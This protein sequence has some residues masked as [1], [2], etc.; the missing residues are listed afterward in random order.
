MTD[1]ERQRTMD[2]I[3]QQQAQFA[4]GMQRLE[5]QQ[6]RFAEQQTRFAEQQTKFSESQRR[7][8]DR[9]DQLRRVVLMTVRQFSRERRD[10]RERIAAL[11]DSQMRTEDAMR[12][13][14]ATTERNSMDIAALARTHKGDDKANGEG[15]G[16]GASS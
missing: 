5:V 1:E 7:A 9:I 14:T 12:S 16:G 11:V 2:F 13:L 10:R 4:A 15:N 6:S 8:D 3:L